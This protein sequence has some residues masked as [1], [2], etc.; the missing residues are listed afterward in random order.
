M[1]IERAEKLVANS[2]DKIGY[3]INIKSLK[4]AVNYELV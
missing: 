1:K 3:V 2:R 4:W